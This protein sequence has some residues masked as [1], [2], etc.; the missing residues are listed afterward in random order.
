MG[1]PRE[2][3]ERLR[4]FFK[5]PQQDSELDAEVAAHL[6]LATEENIR[7]GMTADEARRRAL[8][9]FGGVPQAKEQQREARGL[10]WLDVLLQDLRF[11]F[12]TLGRDRG[13]TLI[14]VIIL[15]LGADGSVACRIFTGA[16]GFAYQP[17]S[18]TAQQLRRSFP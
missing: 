3:F 8:I 5:K 7:H 16:K 12:R 9:R 2:G 18:R 6:E 4:S 1:A 13:F 15:G 10:P 14:A 17:D 11:T